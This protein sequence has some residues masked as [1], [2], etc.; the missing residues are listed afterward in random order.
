MLS[1]F[2]SQR[3]YFSDY[4]VDGSKAGK[5]ARTATTGH[6]AMNAQEH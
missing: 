4:E 5:N 1:F 2:E 3:P 6:I